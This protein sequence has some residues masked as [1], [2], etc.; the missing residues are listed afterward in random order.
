MIDNIVLRLV[1]SGVFAVTTA[2]YLCGRDRDTRATPTG[3]RPTNGSLKTRST[4]SADHEQSAHVGRHDRDRIGGTR[5]FL[6]GIV[7]R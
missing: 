4:S 6:G 3:Y 1:L 5:W 2:H 7:T